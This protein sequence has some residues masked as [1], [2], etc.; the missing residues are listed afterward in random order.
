MAVAE[1]VARD[2]DRVAD[3]CASPGS[4]RSRP[5]ARRAG[6]GSGAEV[7][8][9][10]GSGMRRL[11]SSRLRRRNA[12]EPT[13]F[14][15]AS[16]CTRPR[17]RAAGSGARRTRFVDW[18]AGAGQSWWQVL[19]LGPPDEFGS[20]YKAR[21]R[22]RRLAGPPR[23]AGRAVSTST[24]SSVPRAP[25]VLDRR[26]G[27]RSPGGGAV[28]D[29]VRFEREWGALRA[30]ARERG[31]AADRRPADLRRATAAPTTA[32]IPSSSA[33]ARS[34]ASRPTPS[35]TTASAGA[36]RSTTGRRMRATG[37]RWWI[38][39]FRRT[40][41]LVDLTRVDHFRGFVAYW[42]VPAGPDR[43]AT[44]AGGAGPGARALR[45]RRAPSWA[46]CR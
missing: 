43:R 12:R 13:A 21:V 18:L 37:Y 44:G 36:T 38:E 14:E 17:C 39:R 35:A 32:R 26:L 16:C 30:Y 9:S 5:A 1:D 11:V 7:R 29:Q 33:P 20:P 15:R 3:A 23:R 42:A 24:R 28:A 40:F 31:I 19:P 46:R 27:A 41:E 4:G 25:S 22:V 8:S 6:S 45:R 10:V 2:L 34:P